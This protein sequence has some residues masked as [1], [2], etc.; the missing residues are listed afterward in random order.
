MDLMKFVVRSEDKEVS[1]LPEITETASPMNSEE[2]LSNQPSAVAPKRTINETG[3]IV[4]TPATEGEPSRLLDETNVADESQTLE[5]ETPNKKKRGGK[6][7]KRFRA[8]WLSFDMFKGWLRAHPNPERA[9]CTACNI[10]LNAGKSELEKHATSIKHQKKVIEL[11]QQ[12]RYEYE[13]DNNTPNVIL[14]ESN[15][16]DV[17]NGLHSSFLQRHNDH[18]QEQL[19][20]EGNYTEH[21]EGQQ[22]SAM[23]GRRPVAEPPSYTSKA[24]VTKPAPPWK[25]TAIVNGHVTRLELN[26]YK[27][28]YLIL[29]FYPQDFSAVC[30]T[31][32]LSLSD[33]V[34][35]FRA[36]Q[37]EIVA[38]SVDS[39]LTHLAWARTPRNEG[40]L[41][42][43]KIPLLA[44]PTHSIARDYGVLLPDLG[45]TLRAHF[46]IDRRGILRHM[47]VNDLGVGRNIDELLRIT[48][49]LQYVDE[50]ETGCPADWK[51]GLPGV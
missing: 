14:V 50:T 44:D 29:F 13:V 8:E 11:K 6:G 38:C 35:E 31:E 37:T 2:R 10:V 18:L 24:I 45:H 33:R 9:M 23:S 17:D 28:R 12:Q 43:P 40:G 25:A 27:G 39:H 4:I 22:L 15:V 21:S 1:I 51:P 20:A 32:L 30:P 7:G 49:A 5:Y 41:G 46:I 26:D 34:L 3:T 36:V 48:R 19:S 16:T 47:L 42:N